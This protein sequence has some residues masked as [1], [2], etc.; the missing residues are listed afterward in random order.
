MEY[1]TETGKDGKR[2]LTM[3]AKIFTGA[4]IVISVIA[5][6]LQLT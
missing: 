1:L 2:H 5:I 6:I 4:I 3:M